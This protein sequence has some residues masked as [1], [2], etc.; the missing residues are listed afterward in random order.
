MGS[1]VQPVSPTPHHAPAVGARF[2]AG[3]DVVVAWDGDEYQRRFDR[4]AACGSDVHGEAALVRA[5]DPATVLD[6]GCGTGRVAIELARHGVEVVGV[7]F[8]PV[9]TE[10][11]VHP[12]DG[13]GVTAWHHPGGGLVVVGERV[14][15]HTRPDGSAAR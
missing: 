4:L 13:V 11:D 8:P 5:Y 15:G 2:V 14:H 10:V 1:D 6:A 12:L 7:R 9:G 3:H